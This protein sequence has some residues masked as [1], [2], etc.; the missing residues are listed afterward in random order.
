MLEFIRAIPWRAIMREMTIVVIVV[1]FMNIVLP[2]SVVQGRSM[3]P[4]LESGNRLAGSPIPYWFGQP[5]HGDVVMLHPV[6]EDGDYLVKRI[7]GVP[8]DL[9]RITD[10]RVFI[11]GT[12]IDESYIN[13]PCFSCRNMS[14]LLGESEYY[15]MGD[16][17]NHSYDSRNYGAITEDKIMAKVIFRWWPLTDLSLFQR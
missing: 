11:N 14:L 8:G 7:I 3:E 17:R 10:G 5:Q 15:V 13:E 4:S 2:R 16:N 6:E 1:G 9:I 12:P